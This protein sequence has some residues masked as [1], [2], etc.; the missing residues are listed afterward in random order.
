MRN[1]MI[2]VFAAALAGCSGEEPG[3]KNVLQLGGIV[4]R[5]GDI[6]NP[7]W[8]SA[9]AMAQDQ[10]NVALERAGYKDLAFDFALRD[11]KNTRSLAISLAQELV[12]GGAK[13]LVLDSSPNT[14]G[15]ASLIYDPDPAKRIGVP[16]VSMAA[17][18]P[19]LNN[20]DD[21]SDD[22]LVRAARRDEEG[23]VFRT[24]MSALP[25]TR[26]VM[27]ILLRKGIADKDHLK[28]SVLGTKNAFGVGYVSALATAAEAVR[29]RGAPAPVI[30][31]IFYVPSGPGGVPTDYNFADELNRLVDDVTELT[32]EEG[33]TIGEAA[34]RSP[35]DVIVDASNSGHNI[36]VTKNYSAP[37]PLLHHDT[38]RRAQVIE[39]LGGAADGQEGTSPVLFEPGPSGEAF[40]HALGVAGAVEIGAFDAVA[41]DA[42]AVLMLASLVASAKLDDPTGVAPAQ[43]RDALREINEPAGAVVRPGEAGFAE[44]IARV[45]R[46]EPINYEGASG[47]CDFNPQGDVLMKVA[48]WTIE[49][50]SFRDIAIFDCVQPRCPLLRNR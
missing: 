35:P 32:D 33:N 34:R 4:D 37:I 29:P 9:I 24:S 49:Q 13:A 23:W 41:Y 1:L 50:R 31:G 40:A 28:I 10:M 22:P 47:S 27:N 12:A 39:G 25:Q 3:A 21:Q 17:S 8:Y 5:T 26:V 42:A 43:I 19:F 44:A 45:A 38:F 15:V 20:P 14:E 18:S 46:G 11:S 36:N 48:Y 6:A 2:L 30:E 16:T 7:N